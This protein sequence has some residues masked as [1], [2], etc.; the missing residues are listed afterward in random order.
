MISKDGGKN[1][2]EVAKSLFFNGDSKSLGEKI[3]WLFNSSY[4]NQYERFLMLPIRED[5]HYFDYFLIQ[6]DMDHLKRMNYE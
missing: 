2:Y 6:M 3:D 4:F 1:L 5:K